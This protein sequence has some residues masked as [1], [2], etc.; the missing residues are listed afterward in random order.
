ME[1]G[2]MFAQSF[3]PF[4]VA[5]CIAT[6]APT[7]FAPMGSSGGT[8]SSSS[9]SSSIAQPPNKRLKVNFGRF[10][11]VEVE[12]LA[13]PS[14]EPLNLDMFGDLLEAGLLVYE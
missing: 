5:G 12:T 1:L 11:T 7:L 9:S 8:Q 14:F 6:A 3:G 13:S 10:G 2:C 4:G